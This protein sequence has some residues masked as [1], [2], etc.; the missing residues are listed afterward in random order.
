MVCE[1]KERHNV[2]WRTVGDAADNIKTIQTLAR[3]CEARITMNVYARSRRE[4]LAKATEALGESLLTKPTRNTAAH[5][6][7]P[8]SDTPNITAG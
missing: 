2:D 7:V 3:H 5:A 4:T 8:A 6:T 1:Y